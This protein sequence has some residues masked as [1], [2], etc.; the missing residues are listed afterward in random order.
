MQRICSSLAQNGFQVRLVG[1]AG[2]RSKPLPPAA[3]RQK[4]LRCFC[5]GGALFYAEYNI[6]LFLYLLWCNADAVCA[7]DLDT[8]LPVYFATIIKNQKRIYDAHELFTEQ[9]EIVE[10]PSIHKI[11]LRIEKFAVPRFPHGYT[12]CQSLADTF[13]RLY[14][15]RYA[16]IRNFARYY[17]LEPNDYHSESPFLLYQGSVNEGR[18]FE[19]LI[20]AMQHINMPLHIYGKG[21]F[22]TQVR[23]L[24]LQYGVADRVK[25]M[26]TFAPDALRDITPTAYLGI[27]LMDTK[28][29]N[30]YYSLANRFTDYM[31][32]GIPQICV[33][34]PEYRRI[35]DEYH[36]AQLIPDFASETIVRN[37]NALIQDK[38]LYQSLQQNCLRARINLNWGSE[39]KILVRFYRS[40]WDQ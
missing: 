20:P 7:I 29:L 27:L 4:R 19:T 11:W 3:Y 35:N 15:V 21:N 30:N 1:R 34:Y 6:R 24:I 9:K 26:G 13:E 10:R 8:I 23:E 32:A 39:S 12:V 28:G 18:G 33:D 14:G 16:L 31:M 2:R 22:V 37:I 36:F 40:I 5:R 38:G 17:P 25:L